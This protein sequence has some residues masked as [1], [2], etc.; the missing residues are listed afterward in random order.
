MLLFTNFTVPNM[1]N[2]DAV[3]I[4]RVDNDPRLYKN[5]CIIVTTTLSEY[6]T[7]KWLL[8]IILASHHVVYKKD[9][10]VLEWRGERTYPIRQHP[11]IAVFVRDEDVYASS[12]K[13]RMDV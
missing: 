7:A 5:T 6:H 12:L 1:P 8:G 2:I 10:D 13:R 11:S 9:E 3:T 4:K